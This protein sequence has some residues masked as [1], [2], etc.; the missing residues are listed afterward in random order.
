[1]SMPELSCRVERSNST[2]MVVKV[3][4]KNRT[5][6]QIWTFDALPVQVGASTE[7]V[8]DAAYVALEGGTAVVGRKIQP[9]PEGTLVEAPEMP[10][11]VAVAPGVTFSTTFRV[12]LPLT[13]RTPYSSEASELPKEAPLQCELGY[14]PGSES[15]K[16]YSA[17]VLKRQQI[18]RATPEEG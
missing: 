8:Q 18:L 1:M 10:R 14:V 9:I 2:Q 5:D 7:M 6:E 15:P 3:Q 16:R 17:E 13:V 12:K 4:L 11:A